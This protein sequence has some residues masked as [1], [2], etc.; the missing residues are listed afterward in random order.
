MAREILERMINASQTGIS[1]FH[2]LP[3]IYSMKCPFMSNQ[4]D[5]SLS[6]PSRGE[7]QL[8]KL[9][10][11]SVIRGDECYCGISRKE[12]NYNIHFP[13]IL[14][15]VY[16]YVSIISIPNGSTRYFQLKAL[17]E[18]LESWRLGFNGVSN[19]IMHGILIP[20]F[21]FELDRQSPFYKLA[22]SSIFKWQNS[23]AI[24]TK[25]KDVLV[26]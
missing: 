18:I 24:G 15:K 9:L 2:F 22:E 14:S 10:C 3:T 13:S 8:E 6:N 16:S 4:E 19:L 23:I 17:K 11:S 7:E 21:D 12:P 20:Y 5:G 26:N 25:A 1:E